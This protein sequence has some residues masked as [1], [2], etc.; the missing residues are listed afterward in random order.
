MRLQYFVLK[1][2]IQHKRNAALV[3]RIKSL[4]TSHAKWKLKNDR[5]WRYSYRKIRNMIFNASENPLSV[6]IVEIRILIVLY[7]FSEPLAIQKWSFN[8]SLQITLI[9][10]PFISTDTTYTA[11]AVNGKASYVFH[12]NAISLNNGNVLQWVTMVRKRKNWVNLN[13]LLVFTID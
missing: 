5:E 6:E 10:L 9:N 2:N 12:F 13:G 7:F 4:K 8:V 11:W 1:K 3:V